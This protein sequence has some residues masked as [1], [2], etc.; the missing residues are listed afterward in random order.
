MLLV[1]FVVIRKVLQ[2]IGSAITRREAHPGDNQPGWDSR[3]RVRCL[4]PLRVTKTFSL[5][6]TRPCSSMAFAT[7]RKPPMFAPLN[8]FPGV[9]YFSAVS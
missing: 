5:A 1:T 6:Y 2:S 7:F 4:V 9:P 3:L 8:R